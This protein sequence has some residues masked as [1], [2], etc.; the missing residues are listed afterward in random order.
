MERSC[1]LEYSACIVDI[2][3]GEIAWPS[4]PSIP[5]KIALLLWQAMQRFPWKFCLAPFVLLHCPLLYIPLSHGVAQQF[6]QQYHDM[7]CHELMA[8]IWLSTKTG[9][10][11]VQGLCNLPFSRQKHLGLHVPLND[12]ESLEQDV[13]VCE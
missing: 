9:D 13:D 12:F 2:W 11:P 8:S 4:S 1:L 7:T 5:C 6:S 3:W 10:F